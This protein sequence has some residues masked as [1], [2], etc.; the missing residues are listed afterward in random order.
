MSHVD[1][2]VMITW[3]FFFYV[4]ISLYVNEVIFWFYYLLLVQ[5]VVY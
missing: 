1:Y 4:M 5:L 2:D 3:G